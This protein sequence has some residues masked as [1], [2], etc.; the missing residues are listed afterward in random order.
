M[1][2]IRIIEGNNSRYLSELPE[3]KEG[4]PFG[5]VNKRMTDVGGTYVAVNC[6]S[7]Y[8][9]VVPFKD[10]ANSIEQDINN[11][12]NVFKLYGGILKTPFKKYV[13]D[14]K[15][16]KFVVTYDSFEKLSDWLESIDEDLSDY[17]VLIDEYHLILEDMDFRDEAINR[18]IDNIKRY[19]HYSFLSATPIS[20]I[21]E[22]EFLKALPHYEIQ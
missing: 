3:F 22:Y 21:F 7:N 2:N 8:I 19:K 17:K 4:I 11:K 10:L 18:L 15:I 1:N 12:Y 5:I 6:S 9:V 16:K 13:T 14:N 20:T